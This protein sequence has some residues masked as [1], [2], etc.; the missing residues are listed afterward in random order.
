MTKRSGSPTIYD[1][2]QR[3]NVSF[4][5]VSRVI[6]N[7]PS[8][9]AE[10][11]ERVEK[12]I[13]ELDYRPNPAARSLAGPRAYTLALL[14]DAVIAGPDDD[15]NWYR[16]P[17]L[18]EL[19]AG[20]L[21][22][23]QAVGYR[24]VVKGIDLAADDFAADLDKLAS[25]PVDGILLAPPACDSAR[26]LDALDARGIP[27]ARIAPGADFERGTTVRIDDHAAAREATEYLISCGHRR[28]AMIAG[29]KEHLAARQRIDGFMAAI[30]DHSDVSA[31]PIG[32]GDFF[33][34]SAHDI[35]SAMLRESEPPSAIFASNDG[36]AA[37]VI[38]AAIEMGV[39]VP[40]ELSVVGFDDTKLAYFTW[41]PL[42]TV[43]Q[44]LRD[45]SRAAIRYLV[46][47]ID[48]SAAGAEQIRLD[49]KLVA[50]RSV[51][52]RS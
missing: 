49:H 12:A 42:T 28:I 48:G 45:M 50:R 43:H 39:K 9:G 24:F 21:R 30:S 18:D 29:P 16:G 1:I 31:L 46:S 37:G 40:D 5:T 27:F 17:F 3:A 19:E 15:L 26:L 41:P 25:V 11:R 13:R 2:A 10:L 38:S 51:A 7:M 34:S 44:P 20:A 23:C 8:V 6:N 36:M 4:K 22:S 52:K 14:V 32:Y 35:A 47:V 33:P